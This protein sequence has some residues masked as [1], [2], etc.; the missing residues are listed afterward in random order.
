MRVCELHLN[1]AVREKKQFSSNSKEVKEKLNESVEGALNI[2]GKAD[3]RASEVT[4]NAMPAYMA[5]VSW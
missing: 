2:P 5:A 3:A 4:A 1:K